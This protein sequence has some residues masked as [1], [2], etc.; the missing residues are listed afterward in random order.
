VSRLF[1]MGAINTYE[2]V[3]LIINIEPWKEG[4]MYDSLELKTSILRS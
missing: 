3:D 1:G 4:M 2:T